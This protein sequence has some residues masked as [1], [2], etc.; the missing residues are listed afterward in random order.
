MLFE[1]SLDVSVSNEITSD[2]N[3][4]IINGLKLI[5]LSKGVS[6]C[7]ARTFKGDHVD[8]YSLVVLRLKKG[9]NLTPHQALNDKDL[10]HLVHE[11]KLNHI[12]EEGSVCN[13]KH[14][15]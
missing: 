1:C 11:Q 8:L 5:Y 7:R 10:C 3:E 6:K 13:R 2:K 12:M 15:L 14:A 9:V 4:L